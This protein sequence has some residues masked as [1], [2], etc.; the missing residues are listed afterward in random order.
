MS[1][2][3]Q[4]SPAIHIGLLLLDGFA[5]MSYAAI[6]EP[7]RAANILSEQDLYK[8]AHVSVDGGAVRASNGATIIADTGIDVA[9]DC[10]TLFVFAAG[11]PYA[12]GDPATFAWIRQAAAAGIIIVG[13]SAGPYILARA[14]LLDGYRATVHWEHRA[15]FVETFPNIIPDPGLFVIDRRRITCAGGLAGMDLAVELIAREQGHALASQ[16]SDWFIQTEPR[17][18]DKP[19][20][21]ALHARYDMAD[22]RILTVLAAMASSLDEE[23]ER[24]ALAGMAGLSIRQL[25][26]VFH[27]RV[28]ESLGRHYR[29]LRLEEARQLLRTTRLPVTSVALAAGF[30]SSSHFARVFT[31]HYGHRPSDERL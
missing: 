29:R 2:I 3:S 20:R 4:P 10:K 27:D 14:G 25:E 15:A 17:H 5:L 21:L 24:A 22:P 12:V 13:V 6:I 7:Y 23:I 31:S 19:Q 16:I 26:R 11:D 8:W 9:P 30:K 1:D 28:G 18:A